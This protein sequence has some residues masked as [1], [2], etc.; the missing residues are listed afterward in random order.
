[1]KRTLKLLVIAVV[2]AVSVAG[3]AVGIPTGTVASRAWAKNSSFRPGSAAGASSA[4]GSGLAT[5]PSQLRRPKRAARP[6]GVDARHALP[7]RASR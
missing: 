1:M 5:A 2:V 3:V 6:S 4:G 7:R